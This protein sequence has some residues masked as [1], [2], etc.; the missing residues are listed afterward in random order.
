MG[1]TDASRWDAF[2]TGAP[3]FALMQSWAWGEIK[4]GMGWEPYRIAVVD[5]EGAIIACVQMLIKRLPLGIGAIAYVPRGPLGAWLDPDVSSP[6]LDAMHSSAREAAAIMLKVEP[7]LPDGEATRGALEAA[8]FRKSAY[9]NQP[10]ALVVMDISGT[11]DATWQCIRSGTRKHI[12]AA[13][14]A[15]VTV[16][17]G[18]VQDMDTFFR[19][20]RITAKRAGFTLRSREYYE[21]EFRALYELDRAALFLAR[22]DGRVVGAHIAY[23][24]GPHAAQFHL[25]SDVPDGLPSPNALLVWE[26]IKWAKARGCATFDLGGA[27]DEI[28]EM[29]ARGESVPTDRVDGLWGVL[30]FKRGF[31][32]DVQCY[33]G[34]F[35][36]AYAP[37]RSALVERGM[38]GG[39][40]LERAS[41]FLDGRSGR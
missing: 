13:E 1:D 11:Q 32:K 37:V 17:P 5:D 6:L 35:D 2:V 10:C 19:L 36:H 34:S 9:S 8:G 33:V 20:M 12:R 22:H 29:L 4:R 15:G 21:S 23:A 24:L 7:A 41:A 26:Q 18:G 38:S 39:R 30:R 14:E 3:A 27:P 25:A 28:G 31:C 16:E 40:S